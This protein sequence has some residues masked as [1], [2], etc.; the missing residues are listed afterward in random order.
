MKNK[1][2]IFLNEKSEPVISGMKIY[3]TCEYK[4]PWYRREFH[5][6]LASHILTHW[7]LLFNLLIYESGYFQ[8]IETLVSTIYYFHFFSRLFIVLFI[9]SRTVFFLFFKFAIFSLKLFSWFLFWLDLECIL[10]WIQRCYS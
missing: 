3:I 4:Q 6:F 2:T 9:L 10:P 7:I 1:N 8:F 5:S